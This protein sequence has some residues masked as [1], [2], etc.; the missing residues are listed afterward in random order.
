MSISLKPRYLGVSLELPGLE[1]MPQVPG[2][3]GEVRQNYYAR[4]AVPATLF[5]LKVK[6][7]YISAQKLKSELQK[8]LLYPFQCKPR[9]SGV[10]LESL[11]V[12]NIP[13]L[14]PNRA[15]VA[16]N[17]DGRKA[18]SARPYFGSTSLTPSVRS[19]CL[20]PFH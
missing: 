4:K 11:G 13:Q 6:W 15:K 3:Q 1:N 8:V 17:N 14:P 16:Q 19:F 7:G 18:V 9:P 5:S 12:E 20:C 10:T 2:N